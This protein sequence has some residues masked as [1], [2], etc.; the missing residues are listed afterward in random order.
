M[1]KHF[2][3]ILLFLFNNSEAIIW[4]VALVSLAT[5]PL[6]DGHFTLCPLK[7]AGFQYCPGCGLGHSITL[8]FH[9]NF[10][11]SIQMHPFGFLALGIIGWRIVAVFKNSLTLLKTGINENPQ[12]TPS[13][14]I[15]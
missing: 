2:R 14:Q 11:A 7:N 3:T 15:I 13:K 8:I 6:T 12:T 1:S 9:G 4:L 10:A 5:A